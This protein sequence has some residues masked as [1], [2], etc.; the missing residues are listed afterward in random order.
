MATP[1]NAIRTA[2]PASRALA[3]PDG[4]EAPCPGRCAEIGASSAGGKAR[5][6]QLDIA[7]AAG[8]HNTTVSLALRNSPLISA[9]VRDRIQAL[10]GELGYR[11]DPVLRALVTY[12]KGLSAFRRAEP[13]A[14]ITNAP[15]RWGWREATVEDLY[16]RGAQ[17][18]AAE[19]GYQLE[20]FW[21][22]EPGM[23]QRRLSNVLFNRGITG[24]I[25]ASHRADM[26]E[27]LDLDWDCFSA[28]KL[29]SVPNAPALHGVAND[30]GGAIRLATRS[31]LASGYR[32]PGLIPFG[33]WDQA[34]EEICSLAFLVEQ[35]RLPAV[36]RVPW[37]AHRNAANRRTEF[38][39]AVENSLDVA[40]LAGWLS[41]FR[42]DVILGSSSIAS[43]LVSALGLQI[44]RDVAFV[45]L[46]R[47]ADSSRLAGVQ[48]NC[49]RAGELAVETLVNLMQQNLRGR[50]RIPTTTVVEGAWFAG[51]S[52]PPLEI[53]G[54]SENDPAAAPIARNRAEV[55]A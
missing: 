36:Q 42:P 50:P 49:E 24:I 19:C 48:Q 55:A 8:V 21:L 2:L 33:P 53:A 1:R 15:T 12:R 23:N 34:A 27:P 35:Q 13:L 4:P 14:Y 7:R 38:A 52:M 32:R 46:L 16:Y 20:H 10:A 26:A 51:A 25:L 18:K 29:G 37:F 6:T 44:P 41:K 17:R 39:D 40:K 47:E 9:P 5:V 28:I 30:L 3:K 11:P 22:G 43:I 45:D 54:W 31:A